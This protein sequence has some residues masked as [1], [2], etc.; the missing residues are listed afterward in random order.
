MVLG[1]GQDISPSGGSHEGCISR[2]LLCCSGHPSLTGIFR[3]SGIP[4][5]PGGSCSPAFA[6]QLPSPEISPALVTPID[7]QCSLRLFPPKHLKG[8]KLW[9][10]LMPNHYLLMGPSQPISSQMPLGT[11]GQ[12]MA[13]FPAGLMAGAEPTGNSRKR[14]DLCAPTHPKSQGSWSGRKDWKGQGRVGK[15]WGR[16][17][18]GGQVCH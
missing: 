16:Q 2:R 9:K 11:G 8:L 13:G 17:G 14:R 7:L 6:P 10:Q 3:F 5:C 4:K 12:T 15:R 18:G 1:A